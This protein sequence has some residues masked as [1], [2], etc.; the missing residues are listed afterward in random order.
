[1]LI[2]SQ[3]RNIQSTIVNH[4]W[5][6]EVCVEGGIMCP[7]CMASAALMAGS[8]MSSGGIAA[9]AVKMVGSR[10]KGRNENSKKVTERRND[11]VHIEDGNDDEQD[12]AGNGGGAAS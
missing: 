11:H 8:V 12:G 7:A 4:H 9:L 10:K 5:A 1:L 6:M 3:G 2:E